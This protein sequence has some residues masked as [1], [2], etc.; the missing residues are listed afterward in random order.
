MDRI[1]PVRANDPAKVYVDDDWETA[2]EWTV[3]PPFTETNWHVKISVDIAGDTGVQGQARVRVSTGTVSSA[4]VLAVPQSRAEVEWTPVPFTLS[5][6]F[7]E[8]RRS[9]GEG[10][11]RVTRASGVAMS[12]PPGYPFD[13][14]G[15]GGGTDPGGGGGTDPGGGGG[16]DPGGGG[17]TEPTVI[18][19]TVRGAWES[20]S[21]AATQSYTVNP[22]DIS[23]AP[24]PGDKILFMASAHGPSEKPSVTFNLPGVQVFS[25]SG[26]TFNPRCVGTVVTYNGGVSA[27]TLSA[28]EN[29]R[30]CAIAIADAGA[31]TA[32]AVT[33]TFSPTDPSPVSAQADSLGLT[34]TTINFTGAQV[35]APPAGH[36]TVVQSP[37]QERQQYVARS[38]TSV[39][40]S[41]TYD[42]PAPTTGPGSNESS[43]VAIAV[44][45]TSSGTSSGG[46]TSTTRTIDPPT[47]PTFN[48]TT[49]V[50]LNTGDNIAFIVAG[51]P[52][53]T[54]FKLQS[55]TYSNWSD[56]RPK[57]GMHF[58]GPDTG[59]AVLEGDGKAYCL[60][61]LSA[62]GSGDN[63]TIGQ[64]IKIQNYGLGTARSEYGAIQASPTDTV[65]GQYTYASAQNWFTYDTELT[66]NASN[67]V[68]LGDNGTVYNCLIWGHTVTGIGANRDV[69][70]MVYGNTI[71]ANGFNPATGIYSNGANIKVVWHNA[72][73]GRTL[74][75]ASS[76]PVR[77]PNTLTIA[78]NTFN[79][80][81]SGV[82][83]TSRIGVWG[84]LDCQLMDVVN[85]TF[86]DHQSIAVYFEG[87]N[88]N[89]ATHNTINNTDG[90]GD[91]IGW[92]F[93]A[94]AITT[95]ESTNTLIE[96]NTI[97]NC[98]R[99]IVNRAGNR[100][101]DWYNANDS[102]YVNYAWPTGPRY[103]LTAGAPTPVPSPSDR[104]NMWTGNN[105][106]LNNVVN[107]CDMVFIAEGTNEGGKTTVGSTPLST[108]KF[109]GND[110]SNSPNI[111]FFDRSTSALTLTAWRSIPYDRDQLDT[112]GGGT[113]PTSGGSGGG[114]G[115][116]GGNPTGTGEF[117][118]SGTTLI[119]PD[120]AAWNG[121]FING[122]GW[123][124]VAYNYVWEGR[125]QNGA[126]DV[127]PG[128]PNV[129]NGNTIYPGGVL[130]SAIQYDVTIANG[131]VQVPDRAYA[132]NGVLSPKA[133]M[134]GIVAPSNHWHQKG[135]RIN[136]VPRGGNS[137]PHPD[138]AMPA[139][140]D[141]ALE[142]IDLG[143]VVSMPI[144]NMTGSSHPV[145]TNLKNDPTIPWASIGDERHQDCARFLDLQCAA[146]GT[147]GIGS[148]PGSDNVKAGYGWISLPN[149]PW[150]YQ[151]RDTN[152]DDMVVTYIAR[153]RATGAKNVISVP[154]AYYGQ[155]LGEVASGG[156]DALLTRIGNLGLDYNLV[157]EW[158]A[159]GDDS[160]TDVPQFTYYSGSN[161]YDRISS[162]IQ[163]CATRG[164][165]IWVGEYGIATPVT[166]GNAGAWQGNLGAQEALATSTYGTPIAQSENTPIACWHGTG[167]NSGYRLF[168]M[169]YGP[170]PQNDTNTSG[171]GTPIWDIDGTNTNLLTP[172][173]QGHW[174][175]SA[176]IW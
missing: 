20:G 174:D 41:G 39:G 30:A 26:G 24:Q 108:I 135:V 27:W 170:S 33:Q 10:G 70:G 154:M 138:Q 90:Y 94:G 158:H 169:A 93:C 95:G 149:E 82:S 80:N 165:K 43:A 32:G 76:G 120:G 140:I 19:P 46:G 6:V 155:G 168:L 159:Y 161:G 48:Q 29:F 72:A 162:H 117:H 172:L 55:G 61:A 36:T 52:E 45:P 89:Q 67:G 51:Q 125:D 100:S 49:A 109:V 98:Q 107:N 103:W 3:D 15:G 37:L 60:R 150:G 144:H 16:T 57:T 56:V 2:A 18:V 92:N 160:A 17:G 176:L 104:A 87:C 129:H 131:N 75:V 8:V 42:P 128:W 112:T 4:V 23:P 118:V 175:T 78:H 97:N 141:S 147:N 9:A 148:G 12:H 113:D 40:A 64:N 106:Y 167:D 114:T 77:S 13:N 130:N 110:Y 83:G 65:G 54:H 81:R 38:N 44:A 101:V 173:G 156:F 121:A 133:V 134:A 34:Y 163:Q 132:L 68:R 59:T 28:T 74:N 126:I 31:V 111:Q 115:G 62:T 146:F 69:G 58:Q 63:V 35:Q 137:V 14:T 102:T 71:E 171:L 139:Y 164:F 84:D 7:L 123:A 122:A 151:A 5:R 96:S 1:R 142:L 47:I 73:D 88:N 85:N 53:G 66:A 22:A 50:T 79:A 116:T 99:A 152:F 166:A 124:G 127:F 136:A 143:L 21:G 153:I 157:W 91:A 145:P 86:N 25:G 119:G 11:L 105:T